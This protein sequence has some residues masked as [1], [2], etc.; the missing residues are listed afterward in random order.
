MR[1]MDPRIRAA[2]AALAAYDRVK[3]TSSAQSTDES[4]CDLLTDLRHYCAKH[5]IDIEQAIERS[6]GHFGPSVRTIPPALPDPQATDRAKLV[7]Y[8][9]E[10][11]CIRFRP[12]RTC[13][14]PFEI[15]CEADSPE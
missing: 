8:P 2:R 3:K 15:A 11:G 12:A 9:G 14:L 5:G 6:L 4:V 10:G 13:P 1:R 7:H